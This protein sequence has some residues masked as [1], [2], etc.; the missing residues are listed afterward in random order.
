MRV[1][2]PR[3]VLVVADWNQRDA[4]KYPTV[5]VEV[6]LGECDGA[7]LTTAVSGR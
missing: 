6:V 2:K 4:R 1:L 3:S 7:A 5:F